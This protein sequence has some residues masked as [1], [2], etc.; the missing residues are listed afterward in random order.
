MQVLNP[1]IES[2]RERTIRCESRAMPDFATAPT[3][4]SPRPVDQAA[5]HEFASVDAPRREFAARR[6]L[7]ETFLFLPY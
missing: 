1:L 2:R 3:P 5:R 7:H 6:V 4:A